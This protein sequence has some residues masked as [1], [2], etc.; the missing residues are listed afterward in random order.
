MV[1]CRT[2]DRDVVG[3]NPARGCCVPTPTQRAI[4]LGSVIEYQRK[5]G[6]KQAYCGLAALA[7]VQLEG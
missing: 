2:C 6:S 4:T 3:S 1:R 7:G 5:M